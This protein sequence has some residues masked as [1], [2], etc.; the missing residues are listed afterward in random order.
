[1]K[2]LK[3]ITFLLL[4]LWVRFDVQA[5]S[6]NKEKPTIV[7]VHGVWADGT[8]FSSQ[9]IDL[10]AKGYN[11]VSV[12]NSITSLSE[13]VAITQ[14]A[15]DLIKGPVI[16]VGHSWGG[17][18]ISQFS[19]EPK[20]IGL[21]YLAAFAPE[22]GETILSLNENASQ[23]ELH[24]YFVPLN[25]YVYISIEGIKNVF[26]SDLSSKQQELIYAAQIPASQ[27]IF[28]D[29]SNAPAWKQKP[30][31]YVV[32]KNDKTINPDLERFMAR[33]M[34]AKTIEIASSHVVMNSH[35]KEVLK[36]IEEAADY[37][38]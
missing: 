19:N 1:M 15:I 29:K 16:L 21:V 5:Q 14:R 34:K 28:A 27:S 38:H 13:D 8:S 18:V 17:F 32:A 4:T 12:Q 10:Q 30:T 35:P 9:I 11:V 22:E 31:W 20:V 23:T 3:I 33:R 24:K 36:I 2:K 7:F 26:A 37:K 6:T 25:G